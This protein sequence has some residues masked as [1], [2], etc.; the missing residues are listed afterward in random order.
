VQRNAIA[1]RIIQQRVSKSIYL[2]I[3][4]IKKAR[5]AWEILRNEFQGSQK[6]YLYSFVESI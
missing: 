4:S 5:E 1:L 2:R 3:F 6:S